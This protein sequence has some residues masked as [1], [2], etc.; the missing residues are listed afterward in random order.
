M[1]LNL[2]VS[3]PRILDQLNSVAPHIQ[4]KQTEIR[5]VD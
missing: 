3:N 4:I 2:S 5:S 1:K